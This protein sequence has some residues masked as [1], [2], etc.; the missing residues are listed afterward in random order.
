MKFTYVRKEDP[1]KMRAKSPAAH[2][3]ADETTPIVTVDI[4][5]ANELLKQN[6]SEARIRDLIRNGTLDRLA[7]DLPWDHFNELL[8]AGIEPRMIQVIKRAYSLASAQTAATIKAALGYQ[9]VLT[10][11]ARNPRLQQWIADNTGNRIVEATNETKIG[12]RAAVDIALSEERSPTEVWRSVYRSVGLTSRQAMA[13]DRYEQGLIGAGT[14]PG[15]AADQADSFADRQLRYRANVIARTETMLAANQGL[16]E[17][18][19]QAADKGFFERKD[20]KVQWVTTPD[21]RLCP[22]CENMDGELR[23][24]DGMWSVKIMNSKGI[25]IDVIETDNPTDS[26]PQ[27]RCTSILV[28]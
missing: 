7:L 24:A 27:C 6:V 2:I 25:T 20:A 18:W 13:V 28:L 5:R 10:F 4:L 16:N 26:H 17:G 22:T 3:A 8:A 19:E 21:D 14:N 1:R 23:D 12:V 11:D 15:L 9:P